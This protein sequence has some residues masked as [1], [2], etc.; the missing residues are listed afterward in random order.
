MTLNS[1][2]NRNHYYQ[3]NLR[4]YNSSF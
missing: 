3:F 4:Y 1:I 2:D